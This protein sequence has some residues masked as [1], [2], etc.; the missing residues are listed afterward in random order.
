MSELRSVQH[1]I[2]ILWSRV[3]GVEALRD[4]RDL[5]E[6]HDAL[7]TRVSSVEERVTLHHVQEFMHRTILIEQKDWG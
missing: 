2:E 4:M 6:G 5:H 3:D 7:S 1:D